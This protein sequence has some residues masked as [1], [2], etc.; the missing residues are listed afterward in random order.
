MQLMAQMWPLTADLPGQ[1]SREEAPATLLNTVN[2]HLAT[3]GVTVLLGLLGGGLALSLAFAL[4]RRAAGHRLTR[5][6]VTVFCWGLRLLTVA[7]PIVVGAGQLSGRAS[8]LSTD[9]FGV[10]SLVMPLLLVPLACLTWFTLGRLG[11]W[12]ALADRFEQTPANNRHLQQAFQRVSHPLL[13]SAAV[14]ALPLLVLLPVLLIDRA[15]SISIQLPIQKLLASQ[16]D[17][18]L[19]LTLLASLFGTAGLL[20]LRRLLGHLTHALDPQHSRMSALWKTT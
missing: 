20:V 4:H 11:G 1:V 13:I 12:L 8:P 2:V 19:I 18:M 15:P 7:L 10:L 3:Q 14:T 9:S 17:A 16:Q 5:W 6:P